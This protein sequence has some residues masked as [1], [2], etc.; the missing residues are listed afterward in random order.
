MYMDLSRDIRRLKSALI[1]GQVEDADPK[2]HDWFKAER[3]FYTP[4]TLRSML[5]MM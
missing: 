1:I 2:Y 5:R 4:R 3:P